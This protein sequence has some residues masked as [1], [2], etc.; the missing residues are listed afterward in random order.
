MSDK[1]KGPAENPKAFTET[2]IGLSPEAQTEIDKQDWGEDNP[3]DMLEDEEGTYQVIQPEKTIKSE[4]TNEVVP[5]DESTDPKSEPPTEQPGDKGDVEGKPPE[6]KS[7]SYDDLIKELDEGTDVLIT[8]PSDPEGKS[9]PLKDVLENYTKTLKDHENDEN[10]KKSN[11]EKSQALS[12]DRIA[13]DTE[14]TEFD[15]KVSDYDAVISEINVEEA[16]KMIGDEDFLESTDEYYEGKDANPIRKIIKAVN[17]LSEKKVK[18]ENDSLV[19]QNKADTVRIEAINADIKTIQDEDESYKN[20]DKLDELA[21]YAGKHEVKLPIALKLM[22]HDAM[23][24]ENEKLTGEVEKLTKELKSRNDEITK[25]RK[26][27]GYIEPVPDPV[28]SG[29]NGEH[30]SKPADSWGGAKERIKKTL[31]M[32]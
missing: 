13:L 5:G 3:D 4:K 28:S 26:N 21:E 20:Q 10:W 27:P 17:G 11:T 15:K 6:I 18:A 24:T 22:K 7:V 1:F 16:I 19:E 8:N 12:D 31:N 9:V 23:T 29:P 2:D 14:K 30:E 32:T 25:M